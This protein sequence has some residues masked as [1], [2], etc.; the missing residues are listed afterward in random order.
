VQ[1]AAE[2][3]QVYLN[4]P[5]DFEVLALTDGR[6]QGVGP[7]M[8]GT[9]YKLGPMALLRIVEASENPE[10]CINLRVIITSERAQCLDRG[11]ILSMGVEPADLDFIAV[12]S[13][14]HFR[15]DFEQVAGEIILAACPGA[16]ICD[17]SAIPYTRLREE[18]RL[19][20]R[21]V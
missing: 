18:I 9:E 5:G 2:T 10:D 12:K 16:N 1:V 20:Q 15:N 19:P 14:V 8:K 11:F 17:V 13:S 6:F 21:G 3:P 4:H 7:M